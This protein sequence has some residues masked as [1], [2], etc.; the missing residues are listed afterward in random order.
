LRCGR[1][2]PRAGREAVAQDEGRQAP[3]AHGTGG[4]GE[5]RGQAETVRLD[6]VAHLLVGGRRAVAAGVERPVAG[7]GERVGPEG[8]ERL[9]LHDLVDAAG[10]SG[11]VEVVNA[12]VALVPHPAVLLEALGPVHDVPSV[13]ATKGRPEAPL[14]VDLLERTVGPFGYR[15]GPAPGRATAVVGVDSPVGPAARLAASHLQGPML[16]I[17]QLDHL[18][19]L[20][21]Q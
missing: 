14:R 13:R 12:E 16:T 10:V 15:G 4:A 1:G 11:V 20:V 18:L 6:D 21:A 9:G 8:E 7:L 2:P 3:G 19:S 5:M 17:A